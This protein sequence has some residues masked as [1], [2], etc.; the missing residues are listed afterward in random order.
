MKSQW[1]KMMWMTNQHQYSSF[2]KA[3]ESAQLLSDFIVDPS[4]GVLVVDV[5]NM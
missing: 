5:M 4:F 2:L 3:R 1:R